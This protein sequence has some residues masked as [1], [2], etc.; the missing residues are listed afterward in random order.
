MRTSSITWQAFA[1][2]ATEYVSDIITHEVLMMHGAGTAD[3]THAT[4]LSMALANLGCRVVTFDFVSHGLS[5]GS[6]TDLTLANRAEQAQFIYEHFNFS[7]GAILVGFSM[8]GQT[9]IDV[10]AQLGNQIGCL[11][12]FAP[13]IYGKAARSA[14]FGPDFSAVIRREG[15]W[16]RSDAWDKLKEFQG[17]LIT[18][19]SPNDTIIPTEVIELI[20]NSATQSDL[21]LRVRI[22][23]APHMM[24]VWMNEDTERAKWFASVITRVAGGI[25]NL[26]TTR[27]RIAGVDAEVIL[28]QSKKIL[29]R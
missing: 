13:A 27:A 7:G 17:K 29:L 9:A 26:G 11:I 3:Q 18:F 21:S 23:N 20:H 5:T 14:H 15:S 8:G 28:A 10:M 2:A 1:I 24:G 6:V 22:N 12:L 16:R 4:N 19:E 25:K